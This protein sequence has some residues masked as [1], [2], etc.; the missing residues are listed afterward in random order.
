[1]HSPP[2]AGF[3]DRQSG[4]TLAV[5]YFQIQGGF[6]EDQYFRDGV[7][8]DIIIE[9]ARLPGLSVLSLA[10]VRPFRDGIVST[11]QAGRELGAGFV[12]DGTF[13]RDKKHLRLSVQLVQVATNH[14]IW[15]ERFDRET[16][17]VF[18]I[19][20][21]IARNIADRL[22]LVLSEKH[23]EVMARAPTEHIDAY[24]HYL[25]GR[26]HFRQFRRRSIEF[27][28]DMFEQA[29]RIDPE[30]AAA[31]AGVADCYSYLCMFWDA[32]EEHMQAADAASRK[33]VELG[34]ELAEAYVARGVAL[35][36]RKQFDQA[37]TEYLTA[38][39]LN[40]AIFEA[41]YFCAR[42]YY[43]RGKLDRA[44]Y[45]FRRAC[46][47]RP[48]DYQ[49]PT[50]LGSALRG[51]G[52]RLESEEAF[53][54]AFEL[55]RKHL[56]LNPGDTRAIYFSAIALC[57]LGKDRAHALRLA[58]Q[59]LAIDPEEPQVLYNVACAYTLLGQLDLAMD[60]LEKCVTHGDLW[61]RWMAGDPDL[62]ILRGNPRFRALLPR[63]E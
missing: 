48:E 43:A 8:E 44:V 50:L 54:N 29:I 12:L 7:T 57:H 10:T 6:Q 63:D 58:E 18:A 46:E 45:W 21:E 40:P 55:A 52:L 2:T 23:K 5:L 36:L 60:C 19:Q 1:M 15:A 41:Y 25:R 35:S 59:A 20:S 38:I 16:K 28:R 42:G 11:Q 24:E 27:A 4:P 37:E 34:P 53:R 13:R 33:A 9:L 32:N 26:Q 49:A 51:L 3:S 17:D 22:K 56:E 30:Y 61:V 62:E 31:Y 47:A 14:T 39:S